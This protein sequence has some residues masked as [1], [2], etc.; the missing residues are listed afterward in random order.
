MP[1]LRNIK[2][3]PNMTGLLTLIPVLLAPLVSGHGRLIEPP[4][5]STMWR[6]GFNNPPNFN[7]HEIYCGGF[8]RQWQTNKGQCGICGDPYDETQVWKI[9]DIQS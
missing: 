5:R 7:D 8:T 3:S 2:T 1:S 9:F 4:S 6:Y